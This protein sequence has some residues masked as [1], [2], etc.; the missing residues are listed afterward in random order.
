M[1]KRWAS[2]ALSPVTLMITLL[3]SSL[4]SGAKVQL[5][6]DIDKEKGIYL[7]KI[8]FSCII[9]SKQKRPCELSQS[10]FRILQYASVP[11]L[12][13]SLLKTRK[14]EWAAEPSE[15]QHF[16]TLCDHILEQCT[17]RANKVTM[18][19]RSHDILFSS[20]THAEKN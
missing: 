7:V 5:I 13:I 2:Q 12:A 1:L 20:R 8:R 16:F 3:L 15:S 11:F 17:R 6:I 9:P 4:K 10:R 19:V 18:M 14:L